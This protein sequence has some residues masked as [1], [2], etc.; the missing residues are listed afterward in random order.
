MSR[1]SSAS[2]VAREMDSEGA[3]GESE[4]VEKDD[5]DEED[6]EGDDGEKDDDDENEEPKRKRQKSKYRQS[7]QKMR[8]LVRKL[9]R[10]GEVLQRENIIF[11][12]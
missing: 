11:V 7:Y 5:G 10:I 2:S 8:K 1:R 4:N 12:L 9:N 3:G 6:G